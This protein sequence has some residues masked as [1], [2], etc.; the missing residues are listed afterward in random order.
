VSDAPLNTTTNSADNLLAA[1]SQIA[2]WITQLR[3]TIHRRP[4]LM[5]EE[6]Q[7]SALVR[8]T[9]DQLGI[10]Y[11]YPLATTG[12]VATLGNGQAP[13][14][15]LRADMDALPIHEEA[16]VE[17]A[18]EVPGKM[19]ACGHDCHTAMLLG[20]AR[21]LK[22]RE[23][24]LAGTVKLFFQPAEEG[25]A[26]GKRM[27]DEGALENPQVERIFGIHVWPLLPTG[28]IGGRSGTF[29][30]AA[31][32]VQFQVL[33]Y[34][35]HAAF[36]Q[37]GRDPVLAAA[38]IVSELQSIVARETD[39]LEP[40]VVSITQI[41]G[42]DAFNV[43]PQ[44]VELAGTIRA[45]TTARLTELRERIESIA[46]H[47]ALANRCEVRFTKTSEPYPATVNDPHVWRATREVAARL[48]GESRVVE[49][50]PVLGGEDF[51]YYAERV[52]GCFVG[53]GIRDDEAG[54]TYMVHHPKFCMDERALPLGAALHAQ[55]AVDTLRELG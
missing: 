37:Y 23:S 34:G 4:E 40:A 32:S 52:P 1:A 21:L 12:V 54:S 49:I 44:Q 16:D 48:V 50:D 29:M 46:H 31:G 55:W 17:F 42:G 6:I 38:R 11:A 30:A 13:C 22:E 7:T 2:P 45:L 28:T 3:R 20:A 9:L 39:P 47:V 24:G 33:G 27:I 14:I 41:H 43:I 19:H 25:G 36:P 18:S 10:S 35:T 8:A 51:A 26:G 5:Y 53:L 15:A